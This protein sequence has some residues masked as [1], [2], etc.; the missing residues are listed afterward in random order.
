[1]II[2]ADEWQMSA[3]RQLYKDKALDLEP[4][5]QRTVVGSNNKTLKLSLRRSAAQG[6]IP[7][8]LVIRDIRDQGKRLWYETIDG[9]RRLLCLIA[10]ITIPGSVIVP[11][12]IYSD[13]SLEAAIELYENLNQTSKIHTTG[14][15]IKAEL[16][17]PS[18]AKCLRKFAENPTWEVY[19]PRNSEVSR[20]RGYSYGVYF[21][22]QAHGVDLP[23]KKHILNFIHTFNP[24]DYNEEKVEEVRDLVDTLQNV[25]KQAY[26]I[27]SSRLKDPTSF[28]PMRWLYGVTLSNPKVADKPV[29][30]LAKGLVSWLNEYNPADINTSKPLRNGHATSPAFKA[31]ENALLAA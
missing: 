28:W 15:H 14:E 7:T 13:M 5:Y 26:A 23:S 18:T 11:V 31:L 10:D 27:D 3:I 6:R 17:R 1:M 30:R 29:R 8:S 9:R 22:A 20:Y 16:Q 4:A 12:S 24:K 19:D 21:F 25:V 2:K